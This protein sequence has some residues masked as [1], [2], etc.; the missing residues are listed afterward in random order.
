MHLHRRMTCTF[1]AP[2][3]PA[4]GPFLAAAMALRWSAD[5][6]S[7]RLRFIPVPPVFELVQP[8]QEGWA[9]QP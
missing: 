8:K 6:P 1:T 3:L 5:C 7:L 9:W 4:S 2:P